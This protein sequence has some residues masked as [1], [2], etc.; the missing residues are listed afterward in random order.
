MLK[1]FIN[2][3]NDGDS[4]AIIGFLGIITLSGMAYLTYKNL[5]RRADNSHIQTLSEINVDGE[6]EDQA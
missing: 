1:K 4:K 2:W 3:V 5:T 6:V